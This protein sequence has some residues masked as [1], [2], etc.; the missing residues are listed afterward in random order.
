MYESYHL[1]L[2]LPAQPSLTVKHLI[3]CP[4][5]TGF[6]CC[7]CHQNIY[8]SSLLV[9][10][11]RSLAKL[12]QCVRNTSH[13]N[14]LLWKPGWMAWKKIEDSYV[15]YIRM[16]IRFSV[17][18]LFWVSELAGKI[19]CLT[20]DVQRWASWQRFEKGGPSR[21]KLRRTQIT[22]HQMERTWRERRKQLGRHFCP[23]TTQL[24]SHFHVNLQAG[25][26][27]KNSS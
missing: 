1:W 12:T 15:Q 24:G 3:Y 2:K 18:G 10:E 25:L 19:N 21:R 13:W 14:V 7:F 11:S 23:K 6:F 16:N 20:S 9:A 8:F 26:A 22:A 27:A 17:S 5:S 4:Q